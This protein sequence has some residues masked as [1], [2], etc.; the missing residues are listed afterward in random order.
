MLVCN[1]Y[2]NHVLNSMTAH[3]DEVTQNTRADFEHSLKHNA[4]AAL[5]TIG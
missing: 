2:L 4:I 3:G 1:D 5:A